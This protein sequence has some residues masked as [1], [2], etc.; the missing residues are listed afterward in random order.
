M[1]TTWQNILDLIIPPTPAGK[2][3]RSLDSQTLTK[4]Y[5]PRYFTSHI[6]LSN[7]SNQYI[8]ALI[9]DNKFQA[10]PTAATWLA[11]LL[12]TYIK[13]LETEVILIP[14]P[15]SHNRKKKRGH[16]Q[17]ATILTQIDTTSLSTNISIHHCLTRTRD[18]PPQT[19]LSRADRLKNVRNVFKAHK[20]P[21]T[22][23]TQIL[24]VDD[25]TTT[26]ATLSAAK[27]AVQKVISKNTQ[28]QTV[29]LAH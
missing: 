15:L 18:T 13:S 7:Y 11:Q 9:T 6:A 27:Q 20:I 24:I 28:I 1:F 21:I 17:V 22:E 19:T 3:I 25:V 8:H 29:A 2:L 23:S 4:L 26:G 16:N 10:N 14:I 12:T 5:T